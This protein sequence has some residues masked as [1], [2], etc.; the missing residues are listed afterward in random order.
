MILKRLFSRK[1]DIAEK[2][3]AAIVAAAR[4]PAFYRDLAVPDNIDGRFDMV[5]LHVFLV[6]DRLRSE[7]ESVAALRQDLTD[8]FFA[9]MDQSLRQMGVGDI[10]VGKKVRKMAE[11]FFGRIGAYQTALGNDPDTLQAAL[12]RNIY[13]GQPEATAAAL[14]AWVRQARTVLAAQ[15]KENIIGGKLEF[16]ENHRS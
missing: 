5:T 11:A 16:H 10:S 12:A 8:T 1:P 9:D 4:Q 7:G 14:A 3:Y 6:L 13:V 15:S 2:L